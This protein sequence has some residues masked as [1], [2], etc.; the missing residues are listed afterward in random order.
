MMFDHDNVVNWWP[1]PQVLQSVMYNL[2]LGSLYNDYSN[3]KNGPA[4]LD[5]APVQQAMNTADQALNKIEKVGDKLEAGL[6]KVGNM[7]EGVIPGVGDKTKKSKSG[8]KKG[9]KNSE[10]EPLTVGRE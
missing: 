3:P 5:R 7:V 1:E 2:N 8:V 4:F 9:G 6:N 10:A